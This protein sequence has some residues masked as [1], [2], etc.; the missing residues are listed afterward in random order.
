[1]RLLN[2]IHRLPLI[3]SYL[4]RKHIDLVICVFFGVWVICSVMY[5]FYYDE[6]YIKYALQ[7]MHYTDISVL[8][9]IPI[10]ALYGFMKQIARITVLGWLCVLV[11]N[12]YQ[13][14]SGF[15]DKW[16]CIFW[17]GFIFMFMILFYLFEI[18]KYYNK[19]FNHKNYK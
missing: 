2:Y 11:V 10:L 13:L 9:F 3:I 12:T 1:M 16:Y 14:H 8:S 4:I 6:Y 15:S 17:I 19:M 7:I 18:A 5:H